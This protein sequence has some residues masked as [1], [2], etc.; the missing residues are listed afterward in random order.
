M[1]LGQII[2]VTA[3]LQNPA[4]NRLSFGEP[5]IFGQVPIAIIP[6]TSRTRRYSTATALADMITDGFVTSDAVYRA[7][8]ALC[9]QSPRPQTFKVLCGRSNFTYA[10]RLTCNAAPATD[11][12]SMTIRGENPAVA[13]TV[14]EA[15]VSVA[16]TGAAIGNGTAL[17]AALVATGFDPGT[18]TFTDNGDG[19]VDIDGAAANDLA[20]V[21][22]LYNITVEDLTADR[23]IA[24]EIA[25]ILAADADWYE[26]IPA[27]AFGE[28][29]L[30]LL[31]TA[32]Q[33]A[34]NKAMCCATQD[35]E[36]L[37]GTGIG[38]VL[39]AA[40]RTKTMVIY[41]AHGLDE[42]PS[43][44]CS[45]AFLAK[46]PGTYMRAFKS[47]S[48]VTPSVLTTAQLALLHADF[49]NTYTG[50]SIGG[51]SVVSGDLQRG[52]SSG[53]VEGYMDTYR[54]IDATVTEIQLRVYSAMRAADKIPMTDPGLSAIK[55]AVL[56]AIKSFGPLAYVPG[57]EVCNV[58]KASTIP[59]I[60]RAARRVPDVSAGATLAGG[61]NRV[62]IGL[63]L[64]F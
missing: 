40:N 22:D 42:Y 64:S 5:G 63:T 58:P 17:H 43:A 38:D 62:E 1:D 30:T 19:T 61:I 12:L 33:G 10:A 13:G 59:A 18:V 37:A 2:T 21:D 44:A 29:E 26:L 27:D 45:G 47:L 25:A 55:G 16:G 54:L 36:A 20:W 49:V 53:S 60:D 57:S 28:A 3:T 6:A 24:A 51:V 50:V 46:D 8:T 48:G 34:T 23:G 32:I 11:V 35:S 15:T 39:R 4:L 52:W 14:L 9:A 56:E 7:A 41:T 31:A